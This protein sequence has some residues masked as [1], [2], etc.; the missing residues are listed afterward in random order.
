M[1]LVRGVGALL[2]VAGIGV[3]IIPL[4]AVAV[5]FACSDGGSGVES[6]SSPVTVGDG[7]AQIVTGTVTDRAGNT[8]TATV[9]LNVGSIAENVRPVSAGDNYAIDADTTLTIDAPGVLGSYLHGT[10]IGVVVEFEGDATAAKD[11]AMHVAAMKPAAST[12]PISASS[13]S[14]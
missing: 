6:C 11:V 13:A 10:R 5:S 9:T 14:G 8:A 3:Y 2:E 7:E 4:V 12:A 1:D